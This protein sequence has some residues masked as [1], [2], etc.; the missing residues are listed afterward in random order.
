MSLGSGYRNLSTEFES[1]PSHDYAR[2]GEAYIQDWD[3][4]LATARQTLPVTAI[5]EAGRRSWDGG[6]AAIRIEDL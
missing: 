5:L 2:D 4:K 6:G 3:R 1:F